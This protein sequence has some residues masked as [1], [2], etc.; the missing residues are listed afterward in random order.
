ME[1]LIGERIEFDDNDRA[2]RHN[3]WDRRS[4]RHSIDTHPPELTTSIRSWSQLPVER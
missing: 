1:I 4:W 2:P 3:A